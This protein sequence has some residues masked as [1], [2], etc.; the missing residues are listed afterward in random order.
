MDILSKKRRIVFN[1]LML[2]DGH[3]KGGH[4][5]EGTLGIPEAAS[6]IANTIMGAGILGI[7]VTME[8]LGL[9]VGTIFITAI[10]LITM[11]SVKLL[12]RCKDI[13]GF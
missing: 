13:T 9:I 4:H 3:G 10:S 11:Y 6:H 1:A 8:K 5:E 12:L 7:P 2:D